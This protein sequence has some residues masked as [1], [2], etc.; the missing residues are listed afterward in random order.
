M[1]VRREILADGLL[2]AIR[3]GLVLQHTE[4]DT[5]RSL[6]R[7]LRIED[8]RPI[9]VVHLGADHPEVQGVGA[10][11]RVCE[12]LVTVVTHDEEPDRA[13]DRVLEVVHPAVMGFEAERLIDITEGR[14]DAPEFAGLDGTSCMRTVHYLMQYRTSPNSLA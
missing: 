2:Q 6:D 8:G 3:A 11:D 12:L 14:T 13:A 5:E 10:T 4:A 7:A 1:T 9:V